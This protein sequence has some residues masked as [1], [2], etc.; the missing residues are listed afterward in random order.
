[1]TQDELETKLL[2]TEELEENV[3][4]SRISCKVCTKHGENNRADIELAQVGGS[5]IHL[6]GILRCLCDE[7]VCKGHEWPISMQRGEIWSTAEELP[8]ALAKRLRANVPDGLV[9]DIE[10]A[11]RSHVAQNYKA[12]VVMCRRAAQ[13]GLE[14]VLELSNERLTLGPL[15]E[16]ERLSN[17]GQGTLSIG[18]YHLAVRIKQTG[19]QGAHRI[20]ELNPATVGVMIH[21]TVDVLNELYESMPP[22][23][24]SRKDC[25]AK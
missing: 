9:E 8:V 13:L 25:N 1:M 11:Q 10:E 19:D 20:E 2:P 3:M 23:S 17:G 18:T 7:E 5:G 16:R 24:Q 6:S 14:Y 21:D 12:S 4:A 15:L 22:A